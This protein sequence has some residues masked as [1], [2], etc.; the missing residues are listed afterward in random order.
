[1]HRPVKGWEQGIWS[2]KFPRDGS[3]GEMEKIR[4]EERPTNVKTRKERKLMSFFI[5]WKSSGEGFML[6]M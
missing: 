3:R 6:V 2:R 5:W 4:E 1:M